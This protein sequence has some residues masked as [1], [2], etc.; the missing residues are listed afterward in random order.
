VNKAKW[1]SEDGLGIEEPKK[2][3]PQK[4][5]WLTKILKIIKGVIK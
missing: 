1:T 3:R 5:N 4:T 2:P